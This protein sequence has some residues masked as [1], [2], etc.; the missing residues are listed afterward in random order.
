VSASEHLSPQQFSPDEVG[1]LRAGDF[2]GSIGDKA[3]RSRFERYNKADTLRT[4][5]R[6]AGGPLPYLDRFT[7]QVRKAGKIEEPIEVTA[8]DDYFSIYDG[9][10]RAMAAHAAGLPLPYRIVNDERYEG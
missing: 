4:S 7:E 6:E 3:A 9:H 2:P 5:H 10:H 8:H 1:V